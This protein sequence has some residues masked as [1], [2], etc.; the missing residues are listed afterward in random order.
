MVTCL[1][2]LQ[3]Y[4]LRNSI[5]G[6]SRELLLKWCLILAI[7]FIYLCWPSNLLNLVILSH[8]GS[9]IKQYKVDYHLSDWARW[10]LLSGTIMG[11]HGG[12]LWGVCDL[13]GPGQANLCTEP[14]SGAQHPSRAAW[15]CPVRSAGEGIETSSVAKNDFYC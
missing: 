1:L 9:E 15:R 12:T 13:C 11:W 8:G 2:Y 14:G 5:K 3:S 6:L 4:K 7:C 10:A